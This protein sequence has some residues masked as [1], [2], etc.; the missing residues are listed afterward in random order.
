MNRYPHKTRLAD[1]SRDSRGFSLLE[2]LIAMAIM[3][4]GLLAV[5]EMQAIGARHQRTVSV[6]ADAMM[7]AQEIGERVS[8]VWWEDLDAFSGVQNLQVHGRTYQ[9]TVSMGSIYTTVFDPTAWSVVGANSS[10]DVTIEVAF[11]EQGDNKTIT[12][13]TTRSQA[14]SK[15]KPAV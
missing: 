12:Y 6:R 14:E 15:A 4:V 3:S 2:V 5:A 13:V 10:R 11:Q 8:A 7:V 9:V 1:V